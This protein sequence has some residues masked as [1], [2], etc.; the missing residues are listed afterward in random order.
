[1]M[2][3]VVLKSMLAFALVT[4][5]HS[6]THFAGAADVQIYKISRGIDYQQLPE[7]G[8]TNLAAWPSWRRPG[9]GA[10]GFGVEWPPTLSRRFGAACSI[11]WLPSE[12]I[13]A[14]RSQTTECSERESRC[15]GV[16][17]R[18][19]TPSLGWLCGTA[20]VRASLR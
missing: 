3:T 12:P 19:L 13:A 14:P 17:V 10:G 4:L 9:S 7:R 2:R 6:F 15:V 8:P 5:G 18:R 11:G 1:M 16:A 20:V